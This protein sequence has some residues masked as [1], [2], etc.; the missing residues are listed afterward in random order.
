M[1]ISIIWAARAANSRSV[2]IKGTE[3]NH[4][5]NEVFFWHHINNEQGEEILPAI[6]IT[7]AHPSYFFESSLG[8]R[9]RRGLYRESEGGDIK[10]ILIPLK[11]FCKTTTEVVSLIEKLFLDIEA[12]RD[13]SEFKIAKEV[14]KG[15][16]SAIVDS[17]ILEPTI[18]QKR[19][20]D[21]KNIVGILLVRLWLLRPN[22][23]RAIIT[24]ENSIKSYDMRA[25]SVN[26]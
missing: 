1:I 22:N 3:L 7:N 17:I 16:G 12:G 26:W 10:L 19:I 21:K 24:K 14:N 6:L 20:L 23:N 9:Q 18:V 5:E 15:V 8:Y 11:R 13:L 2:V 25:C 4:F